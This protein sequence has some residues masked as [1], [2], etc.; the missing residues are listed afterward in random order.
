MVTQDPE[1]VL[2]TALQCVKEL[3]NKN[4][5][6]I[7]IIGLSSTWHSFLLLDKNKKPISKIRTWADT[8][9]SKIAA[10][11]R[12]ETELNNWF[13]QKTGCPIHSI[14]PVWKWIHLIKEKEIINKD[15]IFISSKPEYIFEKFTGEIAIS[16]SVASGT[17]I[18]NINNLDWDQDILDYANIN[19]KQLSPLKSYNYTGFL[20]KD[21][22]K[23]LD[24]KSGIPVTITGPDGALNQIGSGALK[25]EIM[26]LSVG[27]S[28]ALRKV[29][30][31]PLI[32]DKPS[33]WCYY[34]AKKNG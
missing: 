8:S 28:G 21:I 7:D 2:K 18:L 15:N 34:V 32:P 3:I 27:T 12:K 20:K 25:K 14:Y 33:T 13:Y 16:K 30:K 19:K 1:G 26:T 5:I 6:N 24:F 31:D 17:G 29:T 9:Y 11:Y 23:Q 4:D 22:A 10:N